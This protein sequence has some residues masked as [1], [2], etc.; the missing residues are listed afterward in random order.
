MT[1]AE[2]ERYANE[3]LTKSGADLSVSSIEDDGSEAWNV[4]MHCPRCGDFLFTVR[5]CGDTP[6]S[7]Q[8]NSNIQT[9]AVTHGAT[10]TP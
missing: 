9:H 3:A 2:I 8:I 10:R 4:S 7:E 1:E 6:I 5:Q